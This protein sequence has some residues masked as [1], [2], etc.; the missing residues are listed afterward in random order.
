MSGR[1]ARSRAARGA[2]AAL[3]VVTAALAARPAAAERRARAFAAVSLE[4]F[5]DS[6]VRNSLG[7]DVVRRLTPRAG[8]TYRGPRLEGAL[9]YRL[10]LHSYAA[11][12]VEATVNHRAAG[13]ARARLRPRLD[14][15]IE[16]SF[17]VADDPILLARPAVALPPGRVTEL[18]LA[19]RLGGRASRR[20]A[21]DLSGD[22]R[23]TI[24]RAGGATGRPVDG[25]QLDLE[26]RATYR[27][28]RRLDGRAAVRAH[29]FGA[30]GGDDADAIGP[31]AGFAWR[32]SRR[33]WLGGELAPIVF[34][35]DG[36]A[37][38]TG[39]ADATWRARRRLRARAA[40]VRAVFGG[41]GAAGAVWSDSARAAVAW[42]LGRRTGLQVSG[43]A[44]ATGPAPSGDA[45]VTG[46]VGRVELAWLS[47]GRALGVSLYLEHRA[48]D[49]DGGLAFGDLQ[50]TFAGVRLG[51]ATGI[52]LPFLEEVP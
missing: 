12:L 15:G 14:A 3:V 8:V 32:A 34:T 5:W 51:A 41:T 22:W 28:S 27:L 47:R 16:G 43:T 6:N 39:R 52:E 13:F 4:S 9:E 7:P 1:R 24:Y 38:W 21:L 30:I 46:L 45:D 42:R 26:L 44:F 20:L 29:R 23:R 18:W 49:V 10:G 48:Q 33:L 11:D 31:A 40:L 50:R 25:E 19:P 36:E 2:V 17:L 37:A 35:G